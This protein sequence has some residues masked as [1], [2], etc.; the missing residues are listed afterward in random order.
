MK[1]QEPRTHAE[2]LGRL[3]LRTV[4]VYGNEDAP[5]ANPADEVRELLEERRQHVFVIIE[6]HGNVDILVVLPQLRISL[7]VEALPDA[8]SFVAPLYIVHVLL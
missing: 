2:Q 3:I 4:L 7:F 5:C 6:V 1:V 8:C